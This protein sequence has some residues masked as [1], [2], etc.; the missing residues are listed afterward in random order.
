[1]ECKHPKFIPLA[2]LRWSGG[3]SR[4]VRRLARLQLRRSGRFCRSGV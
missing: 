4:A 2:L 3:W 1:M